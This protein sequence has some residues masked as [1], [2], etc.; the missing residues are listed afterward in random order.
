MTLITNQ[1]VMKKSNEFSFISRTISNKCCIEKP[2][3]IEL[4]IN[5]QLISTEVDTGSS[6]SVVSDTDYKNI[7][8]QLYFE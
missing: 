6:V 5:N 4:F 7:F 3:V 1:L 2:F 8:L